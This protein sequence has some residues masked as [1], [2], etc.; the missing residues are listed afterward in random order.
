MSDWA[1]KMDVYR[2]DPEIALTDL[3]YEIVAAA[4]SRGFRLSRVILFLILALLAILLIAM[5][6]GSSSSSQAASR[7][8]QTQLAFS[9]SMRQVW[10]EHVQWTRELIN[11]IVDG[12]P[13]AEQAAV[14]THLLDNV[15]AMVKLFSP[16]Y[17]APVIAEMSGLLNGH[18]TTAAELVA[19]AKAGNPVVAAD[20]ERRW[21]EN[22]QQL[23]AFFHRINPN[24]WS[25]ADLAAMLKRHL[26]LTKLEAT[27][28][29]QGEYAASAQTYNMIQQQA[30]EMADAFTTGLVKQHPRTFDTVAIRL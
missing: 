11:A 25:E 29:L 15:P 8:S 1:D 23:A 26:D 13:M 14:T 6:M 2:A 22:A 3:D 21:Y 10:Q 30:L 16:F 7:I 28:R 18:L 19:A 4:Q 17:S 9:N 24:H 12:A 20:A 5:L 27:Q